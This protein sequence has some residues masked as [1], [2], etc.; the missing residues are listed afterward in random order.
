VKNSYWHF[1]NFI[2]QKFGIDLFFPWNWDG[3]RTSTFSVTKT[4]RILEDDI[5][6]SSK[7]TLFFAHLLIP[8]DPYIYNSSCQVY[9]NPISEWSLRVDPELNNKR[10]TILSQTKK[11]KMYFQQ[12]KCL[13]IQLQKLFNSMRS[14]K[15]F[16]N[17][18]IIIHGDHGARIQLRRP[19][20]ANRNDLTPEDLLDSFSTIFAVKA[21]GEKIEYDLRALSLNQIFSQIAGPILNENKDIGTQPPHVNLRIKDPDEKK[22]RSFFKRPY[23][24]IN[25]Q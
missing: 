19:T 18:I 8:H 7:G 16:D 17:A 13:N 5:R 22:Q 11:Y 3:Q 14:S 1:T 21:G 2:R 24:E 23:P 9:K 10:N 6:A 12:V 20:Y 4:M 25:T 15:I